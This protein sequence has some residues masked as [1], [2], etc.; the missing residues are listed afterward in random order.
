MPASALARTGSNATTRPAGP[1]QRAA[2]KAK[3]PRFAPTS[4]T[5]IP[6]ASRRLKASCTGRS[7]APHTMSPACAWSIGRSAFHR[8]RSYPSPSPTTIGPRSSHQRTGAP[9]ARATRERSPS[10]T[11]RAWWSA[12]RVASLSRRVRTSSGSTVDAR[13]RGMRR[14]SSRTGRRG[15]LSPVDPNERSRPPTR[16]DPSARGHEDHPTSSAS[17][18]AEAACPSPPRPGSAGAEAIMHAVESAAK[19]LGLGG[20]TAEALSAPW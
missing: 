15:G 9:A 17:R 3:K 12:R 6:G 19:L 7:S 20:G 4:H 10:A 16:G 5:V 14:Q 2:T 18:S 1:T 11:S 13:T 8:R